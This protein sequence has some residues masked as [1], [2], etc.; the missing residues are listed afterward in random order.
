MLL[1]LWLAHNMSLQK[2]AAN[3]YPDWS[4]SFIVDRTLY[5][6]MSYQLKSGLAIL[7]QAHGNLSV[8]GLAKQ[9]SIHGQ[10]L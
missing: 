10:E 1:F 7:E 4:D 8:F 5:N 9:E 6:N 2:S 3:I